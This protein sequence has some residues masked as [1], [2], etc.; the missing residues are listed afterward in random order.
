MVKSNISAM[1]GSIVETV[2]I[3]LSF[4]STFSTRPFFSWFRDPNK[5]RLIGG[6][7]LLLLDRD[8]LLLLDRD[9]RLSLLSIPTARTASAPH[10][11]LIA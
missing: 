5:D 10:K 1:M 9:R 11:F 2:M 3:K 4:S 6:E 7:E 8:R